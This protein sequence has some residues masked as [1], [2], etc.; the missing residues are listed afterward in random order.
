M[1]EKELK[2]LSRAEL[3]ELLLIQT[4][5]VET[6]REKLTQAEILLADR[7]LRAEMAGSLAEAVLVVNGVMEKA[8][9]AADQY[10]ENIRKMEE[11][12][13]LRCDQ[14]LRKAE[15]EAALL[16]EEDVAAFQEQVDS[17]YQEQP[18]TAESEE[19]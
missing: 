9:A 3:L 6:L 5:E 10:L 7:Y 15:R 8:Q 16:R 19:I 1:T 18:E 4:K 13:R 14:L 17:Y 2:K 12:T 11:Q